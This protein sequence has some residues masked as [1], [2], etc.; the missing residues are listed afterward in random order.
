[1][2]TLHD[3]T[4][5]APFCFPTPLQDTNSIWSRKILRKLAEP[6]QHEGMDLLKYKIVAFFLSFLKGQNMYFLTKEVKSG[7]ITLT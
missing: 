2:K 1:M 5:A 7:G 4:L 3:I 6:L